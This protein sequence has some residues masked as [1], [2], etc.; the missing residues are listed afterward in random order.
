MSSLEKILQFYH[1]VC[2]A[3]AQRSILFVMF[4]L[5]L[6]AVSTS[7]ESYDHLKR[8]ACMKASINLASTEKLAYLKSLHLLELEK[9]PGHITT[10]ISHPEKAHAEYQHACEAAGGS[11]GEI[12]ET[13]VD[14]QQEVESSDNDKKAIIVNQLD[15]YIRDGECFAKTAECSH[16]VQNPID[17]QTERK[18]G[19][20][21]VSC[22]LRNEGLEK[23]YSSI[24]ANSKT[25]PLPIESKGHFFDWTIQYQAD[26]REDKL[27]LCQD[28]KQ[29]FAYNSDD[30]PLVDEIFHHTRATNLELV[31][32]EPV[33]VQH[34]YYD[35]NMDERMIHY[36]DLCQNDNKGRFDIWNGTIDCLGIGT[37]NKGFKFTNVI[38]NA[39]T[40]FP[41]GNECKDYTTATYKLDVLMGM[42]SFSCTMRETE[43]DSET[44]AKDQPGNIHPSI[45][46]VTGIILVAV[47]VITTRRHHLSRREPTDHY[48]IDNTAG[49]YTD[50]VE[51]R[52][53]KTEMT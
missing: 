51:L 10:Q 41:L 44:S 17:W 4:L 18:A 8:M 15:I 28:A 36:Q 37:K 9:R 32:L 30:D 38:E 43:N 22:I 48:K 50:N 26:H 53:L 33:L 42:A 1:Q 40:C 13:A 31:Q 14:C 45:F 29:E 2:I 19:F 21:N 52:E 27:N 34:E 12:K 46:V 35:N 20:G 5:L 23:T 3:S 49:K 25:I 16:Y 47:I 24:I 6:L 11:W 7:S 39:A